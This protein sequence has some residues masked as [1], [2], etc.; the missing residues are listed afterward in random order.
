MRPAAEERYSWQTGLEIIS[1][2]FVRPVYVRLGVD[3]LREEVLRGIARDFLAGRYS[4]DSSS[5]DDTSELMRFI[6]RL[7]KMLGE[8][9]AGRFE[10]WIR[11]IVCTENTNPWTLYLDLFDVW[12]SNFRKSGADGIGLSRDAASVEA[13]LHSATDVSEAKA[14]LERQRG[15]GLSEWD[16]I[17]C[18]RRGLLDIPKGAD[19]FPFVDTILMATALAGFQR[20]WGWFISFVGPSDVQAVADFARRRSVDLSLRY[21]SP[22]ELPLRRE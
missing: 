3:V 4:D 11:Y 17:R 6:D 1:L 9:D 10:F 7:T 20:F 19:F 15:I 16:I 12:A 21:C 13:A 5:V 2:D 18:S 22:E 14:I 8:R